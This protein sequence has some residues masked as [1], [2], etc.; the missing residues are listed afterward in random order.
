LSHSKPL[1][2]IPV[3]VVV[4]RRKAKSQ[5]IEHTWCPVAVLAGVPDT[6]PWTPLSEEKERTTFYVG[7]AE[8]ALYPSETTQY[9]DN[10]VSGSPSLWVVLRPTGAEPPYE[11]QTV[12]A[13]PAEGEGMT[14]T[15]TDLVDAVPMPDEIA[16]TIGTFVLQHHVERVFFKRK[17]D[18]VDPEALG[19]RGRLREGEK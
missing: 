12:T 2:S 5:W 19:R 11:I 13:D 16:D 15:G 4:E 10:L 3:G 17:R 9:R 8:V 7:S 6:K 14:A 18:R 1:V